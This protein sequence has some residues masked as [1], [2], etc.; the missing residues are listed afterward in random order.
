M[1][2]FL[3]VF[4][5]SSLQTL[6]SLNTHQCLAS[7]SHWHGPLFPS[8]PA[9]PKP[10]EIPNLQFRTSQNPNIT[11][12]NTILLNLNLNT[13]EKMGT[14]PQK[15]SRPANRLCRNRLQRSPF[16][17]PF[18]ILLYIPFHLQLFSSTIYTYFFHFQVYKSK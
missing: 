15:E 9:L 8:F 5:L 7:H 1:L 11:P 18:T 17:F 13:I 14:F 3:S 6:K 10:P 16:P 12:N 2:N 4:I